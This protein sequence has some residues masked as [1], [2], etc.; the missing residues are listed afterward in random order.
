LDGVAGA[1]E[2]ERLGGRDPK[3]RTGLGDIDRI[4][5]AIVGEV[6]CSKDDD[7]EWELMEERMAA[8]ARDEAFYQSLHV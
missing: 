7:E 1:G 8:I 3:S 6:M 2:D 4:E 5:A